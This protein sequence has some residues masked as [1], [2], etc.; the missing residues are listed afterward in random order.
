MWSNE[1]PRLT[2]S[3]GEIVI[4]TGTEV[5]I[6]F[7]DGDHCDCWYIHTNSKF[8]KYR[9]ISPGNEIEEWPEHWQWAYLPRGISEKTN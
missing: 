3:S 5:L 2:Y 6:A 9:S 4:Y 7:F 1:D 8:D